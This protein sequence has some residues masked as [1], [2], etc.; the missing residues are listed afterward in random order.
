MSKLLAWPFVLLQY[1]L[2][3]HLLTSLVFRLAG[4]RTASIK[5]FLIRRFVDI[6][7]V[8][9]EEAS[10]PVP[11]GYPTFNDFFTRQLVDGARPVD[12]SANTI[13][14]PVDGTVS[15]AGKLDSDMLLQAK[16]KL[17]SLSDLLMTDID[18]ADRF[19]NGSFATL[20]LA[21]HNYHRVHC[22]LSAS[23]VAMRYVPGALYSVNA[24]TVSILPNLFTRNE[25]LICHFSSAAGPIILIFVGAMHVGSISTPWT[26]LIR[27]RRKGVVQD[28]DVLK[29]GHPIEVAK[30]E[31]L[32]W[33]NMG[34]TVIVLLPPRNCELSLDAGSGEPVRMG[35]AIARMVGPLL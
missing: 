7:D 29:E 9:V 31:L 28:I 34:S 35:Q 11:D 5:D 6:Y 10:L 24:A 14:S 25:R 12:S 23:L 4:M 22:P 33:F 20:Y 13:V 15:A 2:P 19:R 21:P 30:G 18:D 3:K 8:D 17:Y 16:G 27:P 1:L 26:G 32:G